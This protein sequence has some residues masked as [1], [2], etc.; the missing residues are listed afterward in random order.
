MAMKLSYLIFCVYV[1]TLDTCSHCLAVTWDLLGT[2]LMNVPHPIPGDSCS[3]VSPIPT[4][5]DCS[6]HTNRPLTAIYIADAAPASGEFE[7][8]TPCKFYTV[9]QLHSQLYF[10]IRIRI[11][12]HSK[13]WP[14]QGRCRKLL[15]NQSGC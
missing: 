2:E 7:I 3:I 11:R 10:H 9:K 14:N 4:S 6:N 5:M 15:S 8:T 1:R 12:R 13:M